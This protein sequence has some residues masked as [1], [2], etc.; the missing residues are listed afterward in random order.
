MAV[1]NAALEHGI[2]SVALAT[3]LRK[4]SASSH[5]R[6]I[7]FSAGNRAAPRHLAIA[8]F[9]AAVR[10]PARSLFLSFPDRL[11]AAVALLPPPARVSL[12]ATNSE[13]GRTLLRWLNAE[14]PALASPLSVRRMRKRSCCRSSPTFLLTRLC[15]PALKE[16]PPPAARSRSRRARSRPAPVPAARTQHRP[17]PFAAP[18]IDRFLRASSTRYG[19]AQSRP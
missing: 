18:T 7:C 10:R 5:R 19:H 1:T 9:L 13:E 17:A 16:L 14:D 15:Q 12:I 3:T 2:T 11:P 6:A 8:G 4:V